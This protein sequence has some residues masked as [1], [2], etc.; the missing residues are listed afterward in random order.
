MENVF[1]VLMNLIVAVG[2][3]VGIGSLFALIIQL[4]KKWFPKVFKDGTAENFRLAFTLVVSLFLFFAPR[5]GLNIGL[6]ALDNL[7]SSLSQLGLMLLPLF[8][9]ATDAFSGAFYTGLLKGRALIG[10]TWSPDPE[11]EC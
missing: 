5:V 4:G 3:A 9:W 8:G 10:K 7:A 1:D 6:E 11:I 2:G